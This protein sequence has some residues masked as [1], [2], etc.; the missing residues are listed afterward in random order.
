MRILQIGPLGSRSD[1]LTVLRFQDGST[2]ART[3]CF[4]GSLA[5]LTDAVA[6]THRNHERFRREY[7]AAITYC[8]TVFGDV[9]QE[10]I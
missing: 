1:Y 3:G 6:K 2:E 9:D 5:A 10:G 8:H 7:Q 4:F